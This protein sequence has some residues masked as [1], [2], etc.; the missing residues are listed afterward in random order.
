MPN[1]S[2]VSPIKRSKEFANWDGLDKEDGKKPLGI[3]D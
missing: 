3:A 2:G 1:N